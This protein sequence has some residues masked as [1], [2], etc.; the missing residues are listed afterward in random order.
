MRA[1]KRPGAAVQRDGGRQ[2][3]VDDGAAPTY[4]MQDSQQSNEA[5][6]N[7]RCVHNG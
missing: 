5:R 7:V 3:D 4:Y 1:G 2:H 6:R